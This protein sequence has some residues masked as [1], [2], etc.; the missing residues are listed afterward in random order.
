MEK[1]NKT[2]ARVETLSD[3]ARLADYSL[4]DRLS[5]DPE[6]TS[7]GVDHAP[8]QVFSGHFVPVNPTPI[9]DP[10]YIAHSENFFRELGFSDA[11]ATSEN[12]M[13][14]FSGDSSQLPAPMRR[15]S[16]ATGYAL[17][18]YGS[19]YYEQCPFRTGNGYGDGRAI[20]ILE[21]VINGQRWEMQLK[22]GGRTP[23]CR[24]ADGRAVLRSSIREFLAQEHMHALGVPTSR[25]LTL[26]TSNTET[27]KRP[28]FTNGSYSRDPEVMIDEAVA[29]TT[30]V[31]PSFL[32]VGQL[33]LFG[34]RARKNEHP[35]AMEELEQIVL[36]LIDREYSDVIDADLPIQ[37]KVLLLAREFRKRLTSLVANWIRVGYCQG[38][39]NS[40]NCAAGGFTLDYGPFG[41]IDMFDPRYQ[42]WTGGGVHFSFLNQ[43]QAAE[44][45]FH[46]FCLALKPLLES[47]QDALDQLDEIREGFPQVMQGQMIKMWASKLGLQTLNASLFNR[48][49]TLMIE[50]SVDYTIFFRELSTVPE[51][52]SPLTKSFYGDSVS[53]EKILKSW[54]E[55]LE[56]W[57][58]LIHTTNPAD[59]NAT[60]DES[61]EKLSNKMKA[62]NPK[63]TLR[64]W[65]LV[66]AYQQ[67]ANG[68]YTLIKELQEVMTNPYAEQSKEIEERYYR[69]KPS[70]LF[71][72]AGISHV[73]C[74][75]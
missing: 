12:F 8:R 56:Q 43:P 16:W 17:S 10:V 28:W 2:S 30:R 49:V 27:V 44:R 40:D 71:D 58:S 47:S 70:E 9:E 6:A 50:T 46:M 19:E 69:A 33:E 60:S 15:H 61:R 45:N 51:D 18:I 63:Y 42:P 55:W 68:D 4:M 38:N 74:S 22:G 75:S 32:R 41:F 20:S 11:L 29:I 48:L 36:H 53:D 26:Y 62:V 34:R 52:I 72:I 39:F 23:Y 3:L 31:A 1:T 59:I 64:E 37:E 25:S 13:K 21:A 54:S 67:A 7:D 14:M 5:A 57:R 66:P 24:G 73:S 65:F 35:K